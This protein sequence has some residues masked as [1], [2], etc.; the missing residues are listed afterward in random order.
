MNN[1]FLIFLPIL[2]YSCMLGQDR[3]SKIIE[4]EKRVVAERKVLRTEDE[5]KKHFLL[6]NIRF[7][8]RALSVHIPENYKT[9]V[10]VFTRCSV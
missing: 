8:Q 4:K 7:C 1:K 6:N 9:N 10:K 5:W 3:K 2:C